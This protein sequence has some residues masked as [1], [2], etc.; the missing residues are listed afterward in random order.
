[1]RFRSLGRLS[2]R[3]LLPAACCLL[4]LGCPPPKPKAPEIAA[5]PAISVSSAAGEAAPISALT[6]GKVAVIDLWATWCEACKEG[7]PKLIRLEQA[8]RE[9][10]LVVLGVDV[11]EEPAKALAFAAAL[12]VT[13]PIYFDEEFALADAL[14]A[15]KLPALLVVGRDGKIAHR[16]AILDEQALAVIRA[17]LSAPPVSDVA[18][19]A[20]R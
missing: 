3:C 12:G 8:Y 10:G 15:E 19:P 14:G 9:S 5:L 20:P 6:A 17:L 1:M 13:Y 18:A 7:M 4:L 16:G 11:G 2:S